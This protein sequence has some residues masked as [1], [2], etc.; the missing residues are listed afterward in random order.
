MWRFVFLIIILFAV[1]VTT[2]TLLD[3]MTDW[4]VSEYITEWLKKYFPIDNR[5]KK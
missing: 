3:D 1:I 2:T 4:Y 5:K